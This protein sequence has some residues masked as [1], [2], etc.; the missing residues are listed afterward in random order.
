MTQEIKKDMILHR[1]AERMERNVRT[2]GRNCSLPGKQLFPAWETNV[3]SVGARLCR[4]ACRRTN[5]SPK[6]HFLRSLL[7]LLMLVGASEVWGQVEGSWFIASGGNAYNYNSKTDSTYSYDKN[8]PAT[9]FY[10]VPAGD[11]V[12]SNKNDA[13]FDGATANPQKPFLTT[14]KT[15]LANEA[16]WVFEKVDG[17]TDTYYIKHAETGNYVIFEKF[18]TDGN[19]R[20]KCMHLDGKTPSEAEAGKFKI[21]YNKNGF[22]NIVPKNPINNNNQTEKNYIYWNVSDRNRNTRHG[23]DASNYYGGLIGLFNQI[24]EANSK[25]MLERA[26]CATPTINFDNGTNVVTI[27]T[28]TTGATIYYT[29]GDDPGDPSASSNDGTGTTSVTI[30]DVTDPTTIKAIAVKQYWEDSEIETQQIIKVGEPMFIR[31]GSSLTITSDTEGAVIYYTLEASGTPSTEYTGALTV[32]SGQTIR[33][34]AKKDGCITSVERSYVVMDVCATPTIAVAYNDGTATVT[35]TNNEEGATIYYTTNGEVPDGD[36]SSAPLTF[37]V[38]SDMITSGMTVRAIAMKAGYNNSNM[39]EETVNQVAMPVIEIVNNEI[40]ISCATVGAAIYYT[41]GDETTPHAYTNSLELSGNISGEAIHA[42]ATKDSYL[43][44][45][46]TT[47]YLPVLLPVIT[48]DPETNKVV[49]TCVV[50]GVSIKYT[51]GQTETDAGNPTT[52]Y[53]D[54][55][56]GFDLPDYHHV[57][58][59]IAVKTSTGEQSEVASLTILIQ[60]TTDDNNPRPYLIQ[61]VECTDFYMIPG[62]SKGVNTSSLG[63]PSMEWC[64]YY[65]GKSA[66]SADAGEEYDYYY[67]KNKQTNEYIYYIWANDKATVRMDT[68]QTFNSANGTGQNNYKY[69]L[70][71]VDTTDPGYCIHPYTSDTPEKGLFKTKGNNAVDAIGLASATTGDNPEYAHWNLIPSVNKPAMSPQLKA[72]GNDDRKYYKIKKDGT[73]YL[74]LRTSTVSYAIASPV[75]DVDKDILWYFDKDDSSSDE[76]VTY[77]YVVNAATGEYLYFNGNITKDAIDNAFIGKEEIITA[78]NDRY[79]FAFAKTTT[80]QYYILP[81]VLQELVKNNYIQMYWDKSSALSTKENRADGGGKWTLEESD[82]TEFCSPKITL[83]ANGIVNFTPRTR[84]ATI[85]YK[86]GDGDETAFGN[87]PITTMPSGGGQV[88]ITTKTSLGETTT[89]KP[90][91]VVYKPTITLAEQSVVYNGQTHAPELSSVTMGSTE[92][93][94]HCVVSSD[95]IDAGNATAVI[96]QKEDDS[97]YVI[98]GTAPFTIDKSPLT[99]YADSKTVEYGD[100]IPELSFSTSGLATIDKVHVNLGT[101]S[102][103]NGNYS[104]V[105]N[106]LTS[107]PG[108]KYTITRHVGGADASSNYKDITLV[109]SSLIVT[110]K[111][112]GDG[113]HFAE[114]IT[115]EVTP[116][117]DS[118]DVS[119]MRNMT[120]LTDD[121]YEVT[122]L[123]TE[124]YYHDKIWTIT[125]KG[126]YTGSAKFAFIKSD[127]TLRDGEYRA[128]YVASHDWA[129]PEGSNIEAWI[130][131]SVNPSVNVVQVKSVDYLPAGVP[132][133]LT[134][135]ENKSDGF[136]VYPKSDETA[137]LADSQKESNKL[138]VVTAENGITVNDKEK[139]VYSKGEFVLAFEGILS[140]GKIYI[141]RPANFSGARL[142]IVKDD[143]VTGISDIS[144]DNNTRII[145]DIWYSLDG[146][147]LSGRPDQKGIYINNGRKIVVN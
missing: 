35:I 77:Y 95:D 101:I 28:A 65:A 133:V 33:A 142:F 32:S 42:Y 89:T 126:H 59:A 71:Y 74:F 106:D 76:W 60:P 137:D 88:V 29:K 115:A 61:S 136:I 70:V 86:V 67:I 55:A 125:G 15:G 123:I 51:T 127:F 5:S 50:E 10:M 98:Y 119:V 108:E 78:D 120:S 97:D 43:R 23:V 64:F 4:F 104:V 128:A 20:R 102:L 69:R 118:Y 82:V 143:D 62:D 56:A 109:A 46:I 58:K 63:R 18:F 96:T 91:T 140:Q 8:S 114:G 36:S 66:G 14:Y 27:T 72:W 2:W 129:I 132:V 57:I 121:D 31:N 100:A 139:Y 87:N 81:K 111:N 90:V 48:Y 24:G 21:T 19:W 141:D 85:S 9:N 147:K 105:F 37:D 22:Y 117:G 25:W 134:A 52:V 99:I 138:K 34:I 75:T 17:E 39:A 103:E 94:D 3:P 145:D 53:T 116:S 41:I 83:D 144:G 13:F 110:G 16:I 30:P 113:M 80:D 54:G 84:G 6:G 7:L 47:F 40:T 92:L 107:S 146:R 131:T 45:S 12:Q 93:K 135:T 44:S 1:I 38:T 130:A 122:S 49:I 112:L 124:G 11:P 79:L 68:E 26:K 73:N